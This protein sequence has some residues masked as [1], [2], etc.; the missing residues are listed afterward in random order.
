MLELT[1]IF[2]VLALLA[3]S[4]LLVLVL[5]Q[6]KKYA[7][8]RLQLDSIEVNQRTQQLQL[9]KLLDAPTVETDRI[10]TLERKL[11]AIQLSK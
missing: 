8:L 2:S 5:L 11:A 4:P 7:E 9:N 6:M 10:L 3:T 1:L